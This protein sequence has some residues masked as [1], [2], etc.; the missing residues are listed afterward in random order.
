MVGSSKESE[1]PKLELIMNE[2]SV[3]Q[4]TQLHHVGKIIS[5]KVVKKVV[6]QMVMYGLLR[7]LWELNIL[8][9]M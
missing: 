4:L 3:V 1:T 5:R 2:E 7:N 8:V 9:L 6:V